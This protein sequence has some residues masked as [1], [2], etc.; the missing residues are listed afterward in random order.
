MFPQQSYE[1]LDA[2]DQELII[3]EI[4]MFAMELVVGLQDVK[5]E[6]DNVNRPLD[7]NASSV[8]PAQLVKLCTDMFIWE[9]LDLFRAHISKF[10]PVEKINLIEDKHRHLLKVYNS[11]PI[12]KATID[13][14][15][16]QTSFNPRWDVLPTS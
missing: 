15:D 14:Q 11:D 16:H 5:T 1:E 2:A 10:W 8:L 7:S 13:K 6:Q 9:V 3:K 4:G 12:L